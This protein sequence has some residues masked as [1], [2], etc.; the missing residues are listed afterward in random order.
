MKFVK[1]PSLD[2]QVYEHICSQ[3]IHITQGNKKQS[4]KLDKKS[5]EEP[6]FSCKICEKKFQDES[7]LKRHNESVHL[8]I[9]VARCRVCDKDFKSMGALKKHFLLFHVNYDQAQSP[10]ILKT[11]VVKL[12]DI[13]VLLKKSNQ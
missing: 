1:S 4:L 13:S 3:R 2:H 5:H 7:Y 8:E 6:M 9:K 10:L 12:F 11:A